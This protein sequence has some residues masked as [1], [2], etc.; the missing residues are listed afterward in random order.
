[1]TLWNLPSLHLLVTSQ[2]HN[3]V[4]R[5]TLGRQTTPDDRLDVE[6]FTQDDIRLHIVTRLRE[7]VFASRWTGERACILEEIKNTLMEASGKSYEPFFPLSQ[8]KPNKFAGVGG[9]IASFAYSSCARRYM[10][11]A[12][13]SSHFLK[14]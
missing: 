3:Y 12:P 2:L 7:P 5:S 9:L 10:K 14:I 1:M 11:C 4:I 6:E 8:P 13:P